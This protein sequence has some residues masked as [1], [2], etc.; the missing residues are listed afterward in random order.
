MRATDRREPRNTGL[1]A[2]P[3]HEH[4]MQ[5][6]TFIDSFACAVPEPTANRRAAIAR[7]TRRGLVRTVRG[8]RRRRRGPDR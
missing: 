6:S 1:P 3:L 4:A 7:R 8:R 5:S 2:A